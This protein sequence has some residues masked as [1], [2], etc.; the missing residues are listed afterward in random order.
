MKNQVS[1][2]HGGEEDGSLII[3]YAVAECSLGL[4]LVGITPK[5][6]RA[7]LLG[8]KKTTLAEDLQR[9]FPSAGIERTEE[10]K[11]DLIRRA[12]A[13]IRELGVSPRNL[14]LD[15][16]GTAFQR[17]VWKALQEVSPGRTAT[18]GEIARRIGNPGAS[19]AV[20]RACAANRIALFIPCH[21]IIR[22][23]GGLG[24]YRWGVERKR[25]LLHRE[26]DVNPHSL[27][28]LQ[29]GRTRE[30]LF[31]LTNIGDYGQ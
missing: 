25:R 17:R 30:S 16:P 4:V 10:K 13:E 28:P 19:R 3:R 5:G 29:A 9:Q 2:A 23:G 22:S 18:Y 1:H 7:V 11:T 8:D 24:G 6:I 26:K 21:R 31:Q 14:P 27:E 12:V 15:I 20:A